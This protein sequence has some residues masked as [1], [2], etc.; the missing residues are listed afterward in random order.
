MK[1]D[2]IPEQLKKAKWELTKK[3]EIA[4]E[5]EA[6]MQPSIPK[7]RS[8]FKQIILHIEWLKFRL[9]EL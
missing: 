4:Q 1:S 2:F 5:R 8:W 3:L 9:F 6:A 7:K